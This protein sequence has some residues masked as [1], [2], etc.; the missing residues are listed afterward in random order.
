MDS[1]SEDIIQHRIDLTRKEIIN[2]TN[3]F[4][5]KEDPIMLV[6][7]LSELMII[8]Q[9]ISLK[10]NVSDLRLT[11][12]KQLSEVESMISN[13]N[14]TLTSFDQKIQESIQKKLLDKINHETNEFIIK[15]MSHIIEQIDTNNSTYSLSDQSG[16]KPDYS[17]SIENDIKKIKELI[18]SLS[19]LSSLALASSLAICSWLLIR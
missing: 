5:D 17:E 7:A 11:S 18:T 13:F 16:S 10:K 8:N 4:L 9:E 1:S 12:E 6:I 2:Q 14:E 3:I 19:I 15:S